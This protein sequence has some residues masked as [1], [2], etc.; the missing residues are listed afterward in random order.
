MTIETQ[1]KRKYS[2][3]EPAGETNNS[4][5]FCAQELTYQRDVFIKAIAV[6]G[7]SA[8]IKSALVHAEAEAK[9]MI[10]VGMKTSRVPVVYEYFYDG[11]SRTFYIVMQ[12]IYG[13]TLVDRMTEGKLYA[14]E[15]LTA[16]ADVCD[17]LALMQKNNYVHKDLKPANIMLSDDGITYLID[18]G[19]AVRTTLL[20]KEGTEA[21]RAPEMEDVS[22][23]KNMDRSR[24]DIFS[25][26]VKTLNKAGWNF[27]TDLF[28]SEM[29]ASAI[30]RYEQLIAADEERFAGFI[31][32]L[33]DWQ[34]K[35]ENKQ[36]Y[37][38]KNMI[39]ESVD[40]VGATCIGVNSQKRFADLAFD[41]TIIDEAGQIQIHNALV[42]MSVSN[43]LIMLGDHRQI[44]PSLDQEL[45][46]LCDANGIKTKL[47]EKSLFE[48]LY[49]DLPESNK[50]MLDTQF[51]MPPEIAAIISHE[52]YEGKYHSIPDWKAGVS[53]HLPLLSQARLVVIDTSAEQSRIESKI[54]GGGTYNV[55]EADIIVRLV[56]ALMQQPDFKLNELGVISAYKAQVKKI[57]GALKSIL[58]ED[59]RRDVAATLDSFQGQERNVII[60]SFTRSSHKPPHV[61][62]IGFLNELRRLNVAMTRCKE[63]LILVGDMNFLSSCTYEKPDEDGNLTEETY[64]RSEKRFSAFIRAMLDGVRNGVDGWPAGEIVSYD[65]FNRRMEGIE[66]GGC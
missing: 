58:T 59:E 4:R 11:P 45:E 65:E 19:S 8:A 32:H 42:P 49:E 37:S 66:N 54:E 39:L 28:P 64:A 61:V 15:V 57:Q 5:T 29:R 9:A 51:R 13:K 2:F 62:R 3:S 24:S 31:R 40:L 14:R 33:K 60:Y 6:S 35:N 44:P 38:L 17:V 7:D 27:F 30:T 48:D 63:M 43:K 41:V 53:S 16:L 50:V 20:G 46:K 47:L 25:I 52:F 26:G 23:H 36:D 56:R 22:K 10:A 55:L 21:Y 12:R 34:Q 18:F 1:Q